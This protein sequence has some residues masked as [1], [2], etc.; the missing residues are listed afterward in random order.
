MVESGADDG[1]EPRARQKRDVEAAG[2]VA[3][4]A[5]AELAIAGQ[6]AA[7]AADGGGVADQHHPRPAVR[8]GRV[9]A[10]NGAA[11]GTCVHASPPRTTEKEA[12]DVSTSTQAGRA[13][14]GDIHL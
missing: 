2:P 7:I 12:I 3:D 14:K 13:E 8:L 9:G 10:T 11:D 1:N 6:R 5:T 4:R